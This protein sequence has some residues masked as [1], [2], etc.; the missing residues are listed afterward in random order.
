MADCENFRKAIKEIDLEIYRPR[1]KDTL[2][3]CT[4]ERLR[5]ALAIQISCLSPTEKFPPFSIT[6]AL[7]SPSALNTYKQFKNKLLAMKYE[8]SLY[9]NIL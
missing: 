2:L 6:G 5:S 1:L 9:K 8:S 7:R 3:Y 4:L